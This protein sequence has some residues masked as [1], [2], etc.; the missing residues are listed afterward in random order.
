MESTLSSPMNGIFPYELRKNQN[1][2][3]DNIQKCLEKGKSVVY[4]AATGSG[5][6]ICSL[7]PAL[8]YA[9]ENNKKILYLTRT[10]SQQ[11]QVLLELRN[12]GGFYGMGIQGRNNTC[13]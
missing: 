4:Q 11:R 13:L 6:T 10:N 3:M 2:I 8:K 9:D 7:A 12:I 5:K 1:K